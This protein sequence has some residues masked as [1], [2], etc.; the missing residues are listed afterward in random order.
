MV[1][2]QP[3]LSMSVSAIIPA[4]NESKQIGVL[5]EIVKEVPGIDEIIVI[6][7]GSNDS[8][9]EIARAKEGVV[10]ITLEENQGKTAAVQAGVVA[11][12]KQDILLLDA[13][14]KGMVPTDL[15]SLI[16][17]FD[18]GYDMLIL[19]YGKQELLLQW[20][21]RSFPALSGIRILSK[22][23]FESVRF[24][25]KDRFA[26]EHRVNQHALSHNWHIGV[27]MRNNIRTPHKFEKYS[28]V[29]GAKLEMKALHELIFVDGVREAP[30][31]VVGWWQV[32]RY[33]ID[34]DRGK[35]LAI[36]LQVTIK[37]IKGKL[38][39]TWELL[40]GT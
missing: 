26:L 16:T 40:P 35:Y 34:E 25:K 19:N 21:V 3:V 20:F 32:S 13:D 15:E 4:F 11:A 37:K 14:L 38:K 36:P 22:K 28:L 9:A 24:E 7:D 2:Y 10:V 1:R 33:V 29:E 18:L 5:L 23:S 30:S 8:T 6:D 31:V 12:T 39:D 27:V 17:T